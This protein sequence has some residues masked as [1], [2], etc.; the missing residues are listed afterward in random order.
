M[1]VVI[2]DD[3]SSASEVAGVAAQRGFRAEVHTSFDPS[4]AVDVIALDTD[5][6][7]LGVEAATR[8]VAELTR[9]VVEARPDWIYKK[10]DSVLRGHVRAEVEAILAATRKARALLIPANPARGRT[11]RNGEYLVEGVPLS[12]TT[13]SRDPY[14]PARSANVLELLGR[15]EGGVPA[16]SLRDGE[17]L[18]REGIHLPD[19]EKREDLVSLAR[20]VD[21]T[22]LPVGGADFLDVLLQAR[23]GGSTLSPSSEKS[24]E[25]AAG[26]SLMVCGS[27]AAWDTGRAEECRQRGIH[28]LS[29]P[30]GLFE[31]SENDA[32]LAS[33]AKEA[34]HALSRQ[35]SVMLAIG[36]SGRVPAGVLPEVLVGRLIEAVTHVLAAGPVGW[37]YLEGGATASLLLNRMQWTRLAATRLVGPG[38]PA[39]AI[40]ESPE[41]PLLFVKP[42]SY[43]W[44]DPVWPRASGGGPGSCTDLGD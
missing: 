20:A 6:R 33:W 24:R 10:V 32:L 4:R 13:F 27:A 26:P 41:G 23:G 21:E 18:P 14:F 39:F 9:L 37:L 19:V 43:P 34:I 40:S 15:Q 30:E 17:P 38:M 42:G 25:Y 2:A 11:I 8:R 44:P 5:S 29:L 35:G 7:A 22:T 36:R 31:E 1:I 12:E 16:T 28:V 3:I